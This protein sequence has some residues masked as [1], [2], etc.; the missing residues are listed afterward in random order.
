MDFI[1]LAEVSSTNSETAMCP[2][3]KVLREK[4]IDIKK[5]QFCCLDGTNSMLG[6]YNGV[7]G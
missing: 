1:S 4:D 7:Q 2:T 5:N 3:E 6:E